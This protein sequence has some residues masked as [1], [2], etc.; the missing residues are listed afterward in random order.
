MIISRQDAVG[1]RY[2][3][4][5]LL[6][7]MSWGQKFMDLAHLVWLEQV[8]PTRFAMAD[9]I[10][11][12]RAINHSELFCDYQSAR[13]DRNEMQIC[14]TIDCDAIRLRMDGFGSPRRQWQ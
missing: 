9:E 3:L 6:I 4:V 7:A 10:G 13:C 14:G 5:R 2:K 11:P 1:M 12:N 8:E